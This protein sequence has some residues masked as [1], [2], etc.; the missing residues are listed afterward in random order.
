[1]TN[2]FESGN[3]ISEKKQRKEIRK[4]LPQKIVKTLFLS[5]KDA[6]VEKDVENAWRKLFSSYYID[7]NPEREFYHFDS[8]Y[9]T[10]GFIAMD[11]TVTLLFAF[12]LL[13][14]FKNGTDLTK[15][16]DRARITAQIVHYM[17]KFS[18][19]GEKLPTVLVG[20][21]EN[22]AFVLLASNF[23]KYLDG[24]YNWDCPP[25][26]AYKEDSKLMFDLQDDA[27]LS[28]YPFQFSNGNFQQKYQSI[29]DL[30]ESIESIIQADDQAIFK[31]KVSPATIV[32]MFDEF[33]DIA[34]RLPE[35]VKPADSVNFF[36]QMLTA[37]DNEEYYFLPSNHNKFHLPGDKS[38]D[39]YGAKLETFFNHY[40]RNFSPKEIDLLKAIADRLIEATE[41][42]M[43]GDFW[44]PTVWAN[45]ADEILAESFGDNYK[46]EALVW[47]CAAG[48]RNLTRERQYKDLYIS[49][50]HEGE[51]Q[52]GEGYN[53][54]AK[55]VFQYDFLN[56]DVDLNPID[57]P[58]P[59]K[60]KM[61]NIL[62]NELIDFG[63]NDK[64]VI[65]YTNPPYGTANNVNADGS[66]KKGIS[67][68]LMN[69]RMKDSGFGQASQQLYAQFFARV[70]KIAHDFN[71][72]QVGIGFFTNAR[73]FSGGVYWEKFN[74]EIFS[75][76]KFIKGNY[77]NAGEFSGTSNTWPI[78]FSTYKLRK[79]SIDKQ[80]ALNFSPSFTV[81]ESYMDKNLNLK[82]KETGI[83]KTVFVSKAQSLSQWAKDPLNNSTKMLTSYPQLSS[84]LNVA[85]G[86]N[87]SGKLLENSLGYMVNNSNNVGEGTWNGGVW[88]VSGSA[89]K[90]HGFNVLPN[91]FERACV[92][93]AA[94]RS[95]IPTWINAQDNFSLPN[96]SS[97]LYLEF[98]NDAIIYTLFDNASYQAAYRNQQWT[99]T[100]ITGK[101]ANQWFFME[102]DEMS[103]LANLY[104]NRIIYNDL[105]GD[106]E[107]FVYK[108]IAKR[109]FSKEA[110]DVLKNA[111]TVVTQTFPARKQVIDDSPELY[112]DA[113]DAGWFQIK[114]LNKLMPVSSYAEFS[115]SFKSLKT[116]IANNI[117]E[118]NMLTR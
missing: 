46:N 37:D 26:A 82:I 98:V 2:I 110:Q 19:N 88:I 99:N 94:R 5:L 30:F 14:E 1:M 84:A 68:S 4:R 60:W 38:I 43:K 32:G 111:R 83:H 28:V 79:N 55:G 24:D 23:Y 21:D 114:Q 90:G 67:K 40:D 39:V 92:N 97:P 34:Y 81:E 29:L 85:K 6:T 69:K 107:R 7:N 91:N 15:K 108:E 78:T 51:I 56:D 3:K 117:Y 64:L 87:P 48:V 112:L 10:D 72:R 33:S 22:Q 18:D 45:R 106:Q 47:D 103:K 36:F 49:T 73:F 58:D 113:W 16:Y 96:I 65:F 17:K 61:P 12:R 35:K 57:N 66:S 54:E 59:N 115:K 105:R 53:P 44:T 75:Q 74:K 100:T 42:R 101:W 76:L 31:I 95:V 116:K 109:S 118:L 50:Y 25:S 104:N 41:R 52:L 77:L 93:F 27:N 13:L 11:E 102:M 89:Y 8:P 86:K 62:F 80:D 20:A 70:L 63:K 71:L 9:D